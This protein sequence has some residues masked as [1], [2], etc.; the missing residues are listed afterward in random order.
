MGESASSAQATKHRKQEHLDQ[1][2]SQEHPAQY[3]G[4]TGASARH[5]H[6]R[7][8][9]FLTSVL[10]FFFFFLPNESQR[11]MGKLETGSPPPRRSGKPTDLL[12]STAPCSAL[13]AAGP[14]SGVLRVQHSRTKM[15][16]EN[17][18]HCT[19]GPVGR[20]QLKCPCCTGWGATPGTCEIC[21]LPGAPGTLLSSTIKSQ[22]AH[23]VPLPSYLFTGE[24]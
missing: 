6:R 12:S 11:I 24:M 14:D 16:T 9:S 18:T 23:S 4:D 13:H 22:G 3:T 10:F 2:V 20:G 7:A 5:D 8:W 17:R 15:L 19:G 21:R 1:E